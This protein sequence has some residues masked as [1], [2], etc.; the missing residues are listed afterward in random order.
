MKVSFSRQSA[1]ID[2]KS[3]IRNKN[4]GIPWRVSEESCVAAR[5][6]SSIVLDASI[7]R[8]EGYF[9]NTMIALVCASSAGGEGSSLF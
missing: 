8:G 1:C 4:L 6:S 3:S 7:A 9:Y 5:V 2:I